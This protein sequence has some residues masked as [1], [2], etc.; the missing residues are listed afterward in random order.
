MAKSERLEILVNEAVNELLKSKETITPD[1][2]TKFLIEKGKM[3]LLSFNSKVFEQ[4]K[5]ILKEMI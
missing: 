5:I 3:S 1:N 2:I 4:I